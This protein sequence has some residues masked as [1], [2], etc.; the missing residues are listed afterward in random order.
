MPDL[1]RFSVSMP[2]DLIEDFDRLIGGQGYPT[3]SEAIRDLIRDRL[4][5]REWEAGEGTVAGTL[6]LIYDHHVRGLG[7]HLTEEQHGHIGL[8]LSTMHVHLDHRH[9]LEV[10]V[11]KGPATDIAAVSDRLIAAKGVKHGKLVLTTT[12]EQLA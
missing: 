7:E 9:C 11:M 4:V 5:R 1:V 6:T 2:K 8:I 3:R 12:G 10:L